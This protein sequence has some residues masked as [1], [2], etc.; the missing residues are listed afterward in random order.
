MEGMGTEAFALMPFFW[1]GKAHAISEPSTC[2]LAPSHYG[3]AGAAH[4]SSAEALLRPGQ[5]ALFLVS[6]RCGVLPR[7]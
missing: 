4:P 3:E 5:V 2:S 6:C 1:S 7:S